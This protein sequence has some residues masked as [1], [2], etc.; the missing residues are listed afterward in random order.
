MQIVLHGKVVMT[1]L[2]D[3]IESRFLQPQLEAVEQSRS[4]TQELRLQ[5]A[6]CFL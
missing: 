3:L 1:N 5:L 4:S 6:G 2:C